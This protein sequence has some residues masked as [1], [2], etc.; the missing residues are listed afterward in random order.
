M[1]RVVTKVEEEKRAGRRRRRRREARRKD[2]QTNSTNH[3]R[4][5]QAF[6]HLYAKDE[7]QQ[8]K[9]HSAFDT[10]GIQ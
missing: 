5:W 1:K 9:I 2:V 10:R 4:A 6:A 7:E 8:H 3:F